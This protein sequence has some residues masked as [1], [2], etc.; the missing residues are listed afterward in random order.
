MSGGEQRRRWVNEQ[1]VLAELERLSDLSMA[2][3]AEYAVQ[4]QDAARAEAGYKRIRA[5]AILRRQAI[6]DGNG[7]RPSVAQAETE[8]D[9]QDEVADAYLE[10]LTTAAAADASREALRS[11]R[12][13]QEALRTAAASARDGVV[14]P[15]WQGR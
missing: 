15:G 1:Q 3:V 2:T 9:A 6:G 8:A 10:R 7:K 5:Q 13:N 11:I 14:G 4:A 12:T